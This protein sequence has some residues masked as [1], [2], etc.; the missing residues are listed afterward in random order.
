MKRILFAIMILLTIAFLSCSKEQATES[1]GNFDMQAILSDSNWVEV[2]DTSRPDL[3]C[4]NKRGGLIDP[5]EFLEYGKLVVINNK[6]DYEKLLN[7]LDSLALVNKFDTAGCTK[8]NP[9]Q[10]NFSNKTLLGYSLITGRNKSNTRFFKN[11]S[12]KAY[13]L[14]IDIKLLDNRLTPYTLRTWLLV[15]KLDN[16]YKVE[17]DTLLHLQDY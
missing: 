7:R 3:R 9:P 17:V 4:S 11:T 14:V 16:S 13:K 15:P 10:V 2:I 6:S 12:L 5:P 8:T 1:K